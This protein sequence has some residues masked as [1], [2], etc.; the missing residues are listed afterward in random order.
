L[1]DLF[2]Y[3]LDS[4]MI[5]EIRSAINGNSALGSDVFKEQVSNALGHRVVPAWS[6]R[7]RRQN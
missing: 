5:D 6:G 1:G 3:H 7:P 4:G 2:R